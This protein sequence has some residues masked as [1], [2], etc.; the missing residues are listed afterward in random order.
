MLSREHKYMI[1]QASV[2]NVENR[3]KKQFQ[4]WFESNVSSIYMEI[5][6]IVLYA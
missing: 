4:E 3:H 5:I 1:Q 2:K 6:I